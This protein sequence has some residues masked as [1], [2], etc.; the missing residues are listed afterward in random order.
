MFEIKMGEKSVGTA[1]VN[2]EGLYYR[3]SCKCV[4]QDKQIHTLWAVWSTGCRKLG[5]CVPEGAYACLHTK[6]P[7]KYIPEDGLSFAV[8]YQ[9]NGSFYPVDPQLPLECMDQLINARFAI[10]DGK[11]GLIIK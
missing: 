9:R 2:Q 6:I 5:V 10:V 3:I 8:D 11:P 7:I 1:T 4:F